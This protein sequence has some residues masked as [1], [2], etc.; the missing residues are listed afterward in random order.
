MSYTEM[1]TDIYVI[2]PLR[3]LIIIMYILYCVLF[4]PHKEESKE[5]ERSSRLSV[6]FWP[7]QFLQPV[8]G[9]P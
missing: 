3:E 6:T 4:V 7:P 1:W 5:R 9:S 8:T 2:S